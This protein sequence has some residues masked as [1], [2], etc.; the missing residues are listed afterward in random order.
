M[1]RRCCRGMAGSDKDK[2]GSESSSSYERVPEEELAA[3]AAPA[4]PAVPARPAEPARPPR[5]DNGRSSSEELE[6]APPAPDRERGRSRSRRVRRRERERERVE[7]R[8]KRARSPTVLP[9]AHPKSLP[10]APPAEHSKGTGKTV[11]CVHCWKAISNFESGKA[12]H[13]YWSTNCLAWRFW[14]AGAGPWGRCEELAASLRQARLDSLQR[15]G[16]DAPSIPFPGDVYTLP[17]PAG[18]GG[19]EPSRTTRKNPTGSAKDKKEKKPAAHKE[20][21]RREERAEPPV[22]KVSKKKKEKKAKTY[23]LV[24]VTPSPSPETMRRRKRG[25]P[26]SSES[27]EPEKGVRFIRTGKNTFQMV[28]G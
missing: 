26:S 2:E 15:W 5:V 13:A 22:A 14:K 16:P 6:R 21:S 18:Y 19:H 1:T 4:R 11:R 27:P 23:K 9:G 7:V 8:P 25:P 24:S 3:P 20:K 10:A 28:K 17:E 12:Q